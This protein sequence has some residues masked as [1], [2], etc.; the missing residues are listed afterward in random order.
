MPLPLDTDRAQAPRIRLRAEDRR[1]QILRA[2]MR[3]FAWKG[4]QGTRIREIA[5]AVGLTEAAL[6]RHFENKQ[7]LYDAIIAEKI[8]SEPVQARALEAARRDDDEAVFTLLAE[9]L[10]ER[11]LTDPDFMRLLFFTALEGHELTDPFFKARI[12]GLRDFVSDYIARRMRAGAFRSADPRLCT[13][14]FLGMVNDYVNVRAILGQ[15]EAYPQP[16]A[17]VVETFVGIFLAGMR[18]PEHEHEREHGGE[19]R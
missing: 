9:S 11:G 3:C 18:A 8:R 13:R 15:A 4:F 19:A 2:A 10:I 12:G 6:Y 5:E 16:A 1:A 17:E 7:A 14:A